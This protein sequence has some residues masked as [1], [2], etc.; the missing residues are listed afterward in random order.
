MNDESIKIDF[1]LEAFIDECVDEPDKQRF[2]KDWRAFFYKI[3]PHLNIEEKELYFA[4][5]KDVYDAMN[6]VQEKQGTSIRIR[7]C[8]TLEELQFG[9]YA[10]NVIPGSLKDEHITCGLIDM[11]ELIAFSDYVHQVYEHQFYHVMKRFEQKK[12]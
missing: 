8:T 6:R 1:P 7:P 2:I 4:V 5:A 12:K 10:E 3:A 11:T 9:F